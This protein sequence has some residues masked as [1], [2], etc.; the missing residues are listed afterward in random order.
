[1]IKKIIITGIVVIVGLML[2]VWFQR[3]KVL[4]HVLNKSLS[5]ADINLSCLETYPES[6]HR[7]T[8][9][10]LC[11][12]HELMDIRLQG[13]SIN[14]PFVK[15]LSNLLPE[16]LTLSASAVEVTLKKDIAIVQRDIGMLAERFMNDEQA[17]ETTEDWL[18]AATL[19]AALSM[20][21]DTTI[22]HFTIGSASREFTGLQGELSIKDSVI[23]AE[24]ETP[25]SL[26][27]TLH[28]ELND[29][30]ISTAL[31]IDAKAMTGFADEWLAIS[32]LPA[33][34]GRLSSGTIRINGHW[35]EKTV[36]LQVDLVGLGGKVTVKDVP[37]QFDVDAIFE[38]QLSLEQLL[39]PESLELS[40]K[41]A[42]SGAFGVRWPESLNEHLYKEGSVLNSVIEANMPDYVQFILQPDSLVT[43]NRDQIQVS[44]VLIKTDFRGN[45][46]G[47]KQSARLKTFV[48]SEVEQS[49]RTDVDIAA[50]IVIPEQIEMSGIDKLNV[51][52]LDV[53]LMLALESDLA[54]WRIKVMPES[55]VKTAYLTIDE[56]ETEHNRLD[57]A[58]D[59]LF[60]NEALRIKN[61]DALISMGLVGHPGLKQRVSAV[62]DIQLSGVLD[63]LQ[64][65]LKSSID[66]FMPF[67]VKGSLVENE[68]QGKL[69]TWQSSLTDVLNIVDITLPN[70][71]SIE[72]GDI[73]SH[74]AFSG[75]I[76]D[77][78]KALPDVNMNV[79]ISQL[80]VKY[81]D[82]IVNGINT[83]QLLTLDLNNREIKPEHLSPVAVKAV[84][85]GVLLENI[86]FIPAW[87]LVQDKFSL[88]LHDIKG[89]TLGGQF[90]IEQ[91]T[92][93]QTEEQLIQVNFEDF[94]L[95]EIVKLEKKD[96]ITL[97]GK[98]KGNVPVLMKG[99]V[100]E[101]TD[102]II[103]NQG[104]GLI[105]LS[106]NMG[107]AQFAGGDESMAELLKVLEHLQYHRLSAAMT[108]KPDGW[109]QLVTEINGK[110]PETGQEVNVNYTHNENMLMLFRTLRI[111]DRIIEKLKQ[112]TFE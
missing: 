48:W 72:R 102:G 4:T 87:S 70:D 105:E 69:A 24:V 11:L 38:S 25:E 103:S 22:A 108:M 26:P 71:V 68:Y 112:R 46:Q 85:T 35:Y 110:R 42:E 96:G 33:L 99:D 92:L 52:D 66:D 111:G 64:F 109:M 40:L 5:V 78:E 13:V 94:D 65:T 81:Q 17:A 36:Q 93:D 95:E 83:T 98:I 76:N 7:I 39:E 59:L 31:H 50:K 107:L 73:T 14:G 57:I 77:D 51:S 15:E 23:H 74:A 44:D 18:D 61:L 49:L 47:Q 67:N 86:V 20:L 8:I 12:S 41:F 53:S 29:I 62:T 82:F 16:Q 88:T 106:G 63:D 80:G 9:H 2:D 1:M 58:G 34:P 30:D 55:T 19:S 21:P 56:L 10:S 101:I 43:R 32:G 75:V 3:D 97:T 91:F 100:I 104:D 28:A 79:Q 27:L 60:S 6:F 45:T 84:D 54:Q 90:A 89:Q 37:L